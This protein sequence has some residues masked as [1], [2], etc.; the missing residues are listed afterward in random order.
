MASDE[1]RPSREANSDLS[2]RSREAKSEWHAYVRARLRLPHLRPE[3][4]AEAVEELA[5]QLD[6]LCRD[7]IATG[8]DDEAVRALVDQHI[9]D[10]ARLSDELMHADARRAVAVT[11]RLE[12][13][14]LASPSSRWRRNVSGLLGDLLYSARALRKQPAFAVTSVMTLALGIGAVAALFSIVNALLLQPLPFHDSDRLVR[15]T[16]L[17]SNGE[18]GGISYPD[19]ED[20]K[21]QSQSFEEMAVYSS[22]SV[23]LEAA[24]GVSRQRGAVVSAQLFD[25][26]GAS[27]SIGRT[28]LADENVPAGRDDVVILSQRLWRDQFGGDP[29]VVGRTI[30]IE[31]RPVTVVGVIGPRFQFPIDADSAELWMTIAVDRKPVDKGEPLAAQRGVHYLSGI[32]KLK[33]DV[34][35]EQAGA[36]LGAIVSALNQQHPE[37]NPR[38]IRVR[39]E[40][41]ELVADV[42]TEW[43][44][45]FGA[46]ACL[47]LIASANVVNMLLARGAARRTEMAI[48]TALGASRGRVVR[49]LLVE[50]ALIG[51]LGCGLGIALASWG[52]ALI[53]YAAPSN[54]P[55][56]GDAGLNVD[57]VLF[58]IAASLTSI[59]VFG[60][61]PAL[62][63]SRQDP[64]RLSNLAE[65]THDES[66]GGRVRRAI[67]VTQTALAVVLLV[68]GGLFI[69]TLV[70]LN[71]LELGY[72]P[73]NVVT[74]RVDFPDN[75]SPA[76]E[77]GFVDQ[78]VDE[79][80]SIPGVA[81]ASAAYAVPLSGQDFVT[82][83]EIEGRARSSEGDEA[84]FNIVQPD[85]FRTL[86]I[87]LTRGH[88]FTAHDG[89]ESTPV[90]IV[91]ATFARRFFGDQDPVGKHIRPGI[92]NGY[93]KEPLREIVAIVGD[94]R[95]AALRTAPT[96]EIYVPAA[97]CPSIGSTTFVVRTSSH[98]AGLPRQAQ[99]I[100]TNLDRSIPIFA[101]KSLDQYL[102]ASVLQPRFS[103]L[104]LGLFATLSSALAAI[105]LYGLISYSVALRTREIGVR[106]A[107]GAAPRGVLTMILQQ[108][109]TIAMIGIGIGLGLAVVFTRWLSAELYGVGPHDPLTLALVAML[110][111]VVGL[112]ACAIPALRAMRVDPVTALRGE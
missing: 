29:E 44:A 108:G 36:E 95:T 89:L 98:L 30:R 61:V 13:H 102:S 71:R 106:I 63:A 88:D 20:W 54:I 72:D 101:V 27:A 78:V 21:T 58:A 25:L 10:W 59:A 15:L 41:A 80:R 65:R 84:T 105:G 43:L 17:R 64:S 5:Q 57:V 73:S 83:T 48:R 3:R 14:L 18:A 91:N 19:F 62:R 51:T 16:S 75:Y 24:S 7:A 69:R 111:L 1:S 55:R 90:A 81:G 109:T 9:P 60:L 45:L 68:A 97:Q 86:G 38:G 34:S 104:L 23:V 82:N 46:A 31:R 52:I 4:E 100:V 76:R 6:D 92:G 33:R 2:R 39:P 42:R 103:S 74:F 67:V 87:P 22:R 32:A 70:S 93:D 37:N 35:I 49:Q 79:L 47:L 94:V 99:G 110:L 77:R 53:R 11:Q 107:L 112:A 96:S 28:F 12:D 56:L 85:Y 40:L 50:H 26:L 66:A 8:A